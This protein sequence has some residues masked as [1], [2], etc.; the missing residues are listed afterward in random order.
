MKNILHLFIASMVLLVF[1]QVNFGQAPNLG[2]TS[3]FALFTPVAAFNNS[4]T[5]VVTGDVGTVSGAFNA[6]PT[7]TLIGLKHLGDATSVQAATDL[8]NLQGD[9]LG[10]AC[11]PTLAVALG[12]GQTLTPNTYCIL[13]ASTL[14]GNLTLDAQ[15]DPNARF[16]IKIDG[17]L[18]T[19]LNS[20]VLLINSASASNVFWQITGAFTLGDYSVFR[21][22]VVASGAITL[23]EGSSLLG[24]GLSTAGAISLNNNIVTGLV[25]PVVP[26]AVAGANRTICKNTSTTLGAAAVAGSTYSWSSVPVG[27]TSTVSDPI[28]APLVT[29]TYTVVET[30]TASGS[31]NSNSVTVTVNPL[32]AAI[33]GA[34]KSICVSSTAQIGALA[35]AGNTYSWTSVPSGFTS[36]DANP[37]VS[38]LVTTTYTLVETITASGCTNSNSVT[39]NVNS[40]PAAIAGADRTICVNSFTQIGALAV[41]GNTYSWTSV[42]AG[43][44]SNEANPVVS[45]LVATTYTLVETNTAS[46]CTNSNSV[47]VYLNQFPAAIAGLNRS[48]CKNSNTS[49]GAAPVQGS[50]YRWR[51]LPAGFSST[52]SN[53]V[54]SPQETTTYIVIETISATGCSNNNTVVVTVNQAPQAAAGA[55]RTICSNTGTQLGSAAVNG[56]TYSWSS[57]PAGFTS[58][59][60]NPTV[61]PKITTTYRLTESSTTAGC[62]NSNSVVVTVNPAP[63][64][65]AGMNRSIC[66]NEST[67]IGVENLSG[68]TFSW[69]SVP[70]GFTSTLPNPLVTPLQ[71]TTYTV[72]ETTAAGCSNSASILVTVNLSPAAETGPDR[73]ICLNE[74][75]I[76]GSAALTGRTYSWSSNPAGFVSTL[77]NPSVSP[78]LTTTYTLTET[79]TASGC[80]KSNSVQV[81]LNTAVK[82]NTEPSNQTACAG[83]TVR[84]SVDATGT[85]LIYQWRKGTVSLVNGGS[86]SG[87]NTAN[88][89]I[90]PVNTSDVASNYN[91]VVTGTCSSIETSKNVSLEVITAPSISTLV[92]AG[93]SVSFWAGTTG[94]GLTYQW[95][96]GNVNLT[97]GGN[98]SGAT[99]PTLTINPVSSSD[100]SPDYSVQITG[101]CSPATS[102]HVSLVVNA[103]LNIT[104][105]PA[106]QIA[107]D[108]KPVNFTVVSTGTGLNYQWRKGT[109]NLING[110]NISGVTSATLTINPVNTADVASNYN[111]VIT[112]PCSAKSTSKDASLSLCNPTGIASV[113]GENTV[114]AVTIYPNPFTTSIDIRI[115]DESQINNYEMKI[116]NILGEELVITRLTKQLTTLKTSNL[117]TGVYLY[118][119]NSGKKTI[120]SGKLISQQ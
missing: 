1:P 66:M 5:S 27:F 77:A 120:Q 34:N 54:V 30:I 90:N 103:A 69:T 107:C 48:V 80:Q 10:R 18:T 39:V 45:P 79:L 110:G 115:N 47:K 24:R 94:S 61:F 89:T 17:A 43:F 28:V 109:T 102:Q 2:A 76:L 106:N 42:P 117:P 36:N 92:C 93:N 98:I 6:F 99:S 21:G 8:A 46:G 59:E 50:T 37:V 12:N 49:L 105:E 114:K 75:T 3:G 58:N 23:L 71:T 31:T 100:A 14:S 104:T 62:S 108:G 22:T 40:F 57:L 97:D 55:N 33:A 88:L 96:K 44:N 95:K 19:G 15:G 81:S 11:G 9:L 119:V 25:L 53:P 113:A 32:P 60:A 41:A 74:S 68:N 70:A 84:F 67:R 111:V 87:A 65:N 20:N 73:T 52:E 64:A 82:I 85:G 16:I 35:V 83:N 56:S 72:V 4:G 26:D 91:V 51:S 112:G 29:T 78:G 118:Q 63:V 38:P 101:A 86:V 116:F 13:A 7:G